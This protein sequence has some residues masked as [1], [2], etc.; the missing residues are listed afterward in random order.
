[1]TTENNKIIAKF[2]G[3]EIKNKI[4][5]IPPSLP[6]CMKNAEHLKADKSENLPFHNDWNWLMEV[7]EKIESLEYKVDISKWE[8]SQYCGIYLNGKKYRATKQILKQKPFTMLAQNL[9]NG[10]TKIKTNCKR[11]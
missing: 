3:F 5:Y 10:I 1:M 2:M 8:N 4:N 11:L 6:N 9:L 7:V